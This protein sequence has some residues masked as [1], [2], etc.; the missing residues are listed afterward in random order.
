MRRDL[1]MHSI[2]LDM[3]ESSNTTNIPGHVHAVK[4]LCVHSPVTEDRHT[5]NIQIR[6]TFMDTK[7]QCY[8]F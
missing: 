4:P 3:K 6:S 5:A 7:T 2:I 8:S 1:T